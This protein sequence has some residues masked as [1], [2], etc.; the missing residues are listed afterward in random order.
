MELPVPRSLLLAIDIIVP[1]SMLFIPVYLID[2]AVPLSAALK[3][4]TVPLSMLWTPVTFIDDPVPM[5]SFSGD[6]LF[7]RFSSS[8][9]LSSS[10]FD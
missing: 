9:V 6:G 8:N 4:M 10:S 1:A 5:S 2:M 3:D 7:K